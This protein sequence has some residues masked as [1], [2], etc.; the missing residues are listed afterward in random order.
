M[1][2][3][4]SGWMPP[5][6]DKIL[7]YGIR[8]LLGEQKGILYPCDLHILAETEDFVATLVYLV[9]KLLRHT[10]ERQYEFLSSVAS[11]PVHDQTD[12]MVRLI[13]DTIGACDPH[14]GVEAMK[15]AQLN[16]QGFEMWDDLY[17][18]TAA[19]CAAENR[20][21]V[22][23]AYAPTVGLRHFL[24]A[25]RG[26]AR[27]VYLVSDAYIADA[28]ASWCGYVFFQ[29][30]CGSV[31]VERLDKDDTVWPR[32][33]AV[34]ED[35]I[36]RGTTIRA[37]CNFIREGAPDADVREIVLARTDVV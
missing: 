15:L 28:A 36:K 31:A 12:E 14:R 35:T 18:H 24:A 27:G 17:R 32:R 2:K 34:V 4:F 30:P 21:V 6:P 7:P 10:P 23:V 5:K 3:V 16:R 22:L 8:M 1:R 13:R 25:C 29:R 33:I 9:T 19:D 11:C 26:T 37:V 20:D